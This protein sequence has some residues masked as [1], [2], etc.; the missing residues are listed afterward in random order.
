MAI[1]R[2][3]RSSKIGIMGTYYTNIYLFHGLSYFEFHLPFVS[4]R[5]GSI[6]YILEDLLLNL[7]AS[8]ISPFILIKR[9]PAHYITR[10]SE[11]P[12]A[13]SQLVDDYH[14]FS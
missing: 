13:N 11:K 12:M 9:W 4:S 5:R 7:S 8:F 1:G 3:Y 14:G 2:N 6:D 10:E